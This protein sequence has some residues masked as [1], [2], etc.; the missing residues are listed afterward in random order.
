MLIRDSEFKA[1]AT[2][3]NA[4]TLA[5]NARGLDKHGYRVEFLNLV[6]TAKDLSPKK[7]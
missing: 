5:G 6:R 3:E 7:I 1:Q 4:I 2:Y